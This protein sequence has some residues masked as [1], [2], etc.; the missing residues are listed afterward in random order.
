MRTDFIRRLE[1]LEEDSG[2]L[3]DD[4]A[5]YVSW[6]AEGCSPNWRWDPKFEKQME[7]LMEELPEEEMNHE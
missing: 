6:C 5:D 2:P 4:L 3:I 7:E 1:A